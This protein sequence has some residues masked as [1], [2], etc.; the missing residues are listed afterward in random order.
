MIEAKLTIA[1]LKRQ[2][3]QIVVHVSFTY[4]KEKYVKINKIR[5]IRILEP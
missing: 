5:M 4:E 1:V 2:Y 3:W